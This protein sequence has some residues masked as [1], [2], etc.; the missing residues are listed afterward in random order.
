MSDFTLTEPRTPAEPNA[1]A[2]PEGRFRTLGVPLALLR[3][4][5]LLAAIVVIMIV[6]QLQ[7]SYFFTTGNMLELF[8]SMSTLG[9][10]ALGETLVIIAGEIDLSV[11]AVYGFC[12][13][14][15]GEMWIN[16]VPL[17]IA[18]PAALLIGVFL[19]LVNAELQTTFMLGG[20]PREDEVVQSATKGVRTFLRAFGK[21]PSATAMKKHAALASA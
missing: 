5:G 4:G 20:T 2:E 1:P 9:I 7:N 8:R 16:W 14:A 3:I 21:R 19:G 12:A 11:G 17:W 10:V 6:F 13:M 18:F 15:L